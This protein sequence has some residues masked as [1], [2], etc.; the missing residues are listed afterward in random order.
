MGFEVVEIGV[1]A[2]SLGYEEGL[3][4]Y[5]GEGV[6]GVG[7]VVVV[8][9]VYEGVGVGGEGWVDVEVVSAGEGYDGETVVG[10]DTADVGLAVCAEICLGGGFGHHHGG[11]EHGEGGV[12]VV[13]SVEGEV[14]TPGKAGGGGAWIACYAE[15][16]D[17]AALADEQ[18]VGFAL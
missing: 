14:G 3:W 17:V 18:D 1:A 8:A 6:Y 15:V 4:V 7:Y 5:L 9:E 10:K 16:V 12:G 11:G 13:V 2:E